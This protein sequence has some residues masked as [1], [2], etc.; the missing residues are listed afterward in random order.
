MISGSIDATE[1]TNLPADAA[2]P[3]SK[4]PESALSPAVMVTITPVSAMRDA[5]VAKAL[6]AKPSP[7]APEILQ[8]ITSAYLNIRKN[9]LL[10]QEK[11][12]GPTPAS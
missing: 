5:I 7:E 9:R 11:D 1:I 8:V 4:G 6:S 3:G 12:Y 2:E 10:V